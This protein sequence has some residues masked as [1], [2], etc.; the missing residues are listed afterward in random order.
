[1]LIV[2]QPQ[3]MLQIL[4]ATPLFVWGILVAITVLGLTQAR[5]R[6]ASV[7]RIAIMPVVMTVLGF[8]SLISAFSQSPVFGLALLAWVASAAVMI[9][10][11]GTLAPPSD[12]SYDESTR[13]FA[14]S[15]SLLPMA[16]MMAIFLTK[17]FVGVETSM[18]PGVA[19]DGVF[20]LI[21]SALYGMFSGIFSGRAIRLLRL[22]SRP[23]LRTAAA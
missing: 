5:D 23:A 4:K 18:N 15:G 13:T 21:V 22:V 9:G 2:N 8:W 11:I 6:T 12:A 7:A 19:L 1:Q 3:V 10:L 16:L 17:Y 14:V 20:A